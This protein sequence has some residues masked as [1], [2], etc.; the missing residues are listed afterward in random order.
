[1]DKF[2]TK[3]KSKAMKFIFVVIMVILHVFGFPNR[4]APYTYISIL[5]IMGKPVEEYLASGSSVVVH[6]FLFISGYGMGLQKNINYYIIC[7]RLKNLYKEYWSIFFIFVPIGYLLKIYRFNFLEFLQNMIGLISTYNAE[8][9]FLRA[10][11]V[12]MLLYP[13]IY[14]KIKTYPK[15]SIV[16]AIFITGNGMILGKLMR[17]EIINSNLFLL[18]LA[19]LMEYIY[20][21]ICGIVIVQNRI[22][23]RIEEKIL[24]FKVIFKIL[25][26]FLIIFMCFIG[27][28]NYIRHA[29]NFFTVPLFIFL[30]GMFNIEKNKFIL[31]LSEFTTGI[32]LIHSFFC[33]YYFKNIVFIFRYSP[34]ILIWIILLSIISYKI[35]N[36]IKNFLERKDNVI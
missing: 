32:W 35:I 24:N 23:D 34:L 11:V 16:L 31:K 14:K 13:L 22:F 19:S 5:K 15:A 2:I 12:Y 17:D 10:Y 36:S 4:I 9:W 7:K 28:K 3:D 21:F 33:Y 1:M 30:L 25:F 26:L 29:F 20:P 6:L 27:D 18:I 8:W